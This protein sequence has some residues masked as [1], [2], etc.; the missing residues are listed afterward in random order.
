MALA[1]VALTDTFDYWRTVTNSLVVVLNDKLV[2]CNTSNANTV[3]IPSFASRTS[4]LY[5]NIITST[6]IN[7]VSTSNI[8]STFTA[9]TIHNAALTYT[10][11]AN[12]NT[13]T[14]VAS[15]NAYTNNIVASVNAWIDVVKT[16]GNNWTI[17]GDAA[18]NAWSNTVGIAGNNYTRAV[19]TS[20]NNYTNFVGVAGNNYT[21]F[22]SN[23]VGQSGNT[24]SATTY[25]PKINPTFSGTI[26]LNAHIANQTL[27]DGGTI[28]WDVSQGSVATVTLGGNRTMAAPTNLKIGTYILH[29]YQDGSGNRNISWDSIFKWPAGVV[30]ALSTAAGRH[31]MFSFVS[32]GTYLYG[33]YLPDVR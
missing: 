10:A 23:Y 6:S 25:A 31:D 24:Y 30:P 13:Q 17:A 18:G 2:Y 28:Y 19:G 5:V 14:S 33:S 7:D 4:N 16:A 21:V 9:N 15:A 1:N 27:T 11:A 12:S 32:D 3:S 26:T 29:V 8:A 22:Y 20:G